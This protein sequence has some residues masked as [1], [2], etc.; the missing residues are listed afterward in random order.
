MLM[1][2]R[3][4]LTKLGELAYLESHPDTSHRIFKYINESISD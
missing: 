1:I 4:K 2:D 3:K